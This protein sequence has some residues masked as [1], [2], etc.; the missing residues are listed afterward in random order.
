MLI[1]AR[2]YGKPVYPF[3]WPT[4]HNSNKKLTG[5]LVPG[6]YWRMELELVHQY[7]D[8]VVLWG[9]YKEKWD[10]NAA[11]WRETQAWLATLH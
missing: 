4:Y 3:L 6:D 10:E 1:E 11:W 8:G 7:A 5:Q 2:R 9:G